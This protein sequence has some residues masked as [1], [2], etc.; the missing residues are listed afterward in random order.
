M[1]SNY[2]RDLKAD[3]QSGKVRVMVV[4]D[5]VGYGFDVPNI[6]RVITTKLE[7]YFEE[8]EQKWGR[9]GRDGQP[10]EAIAFAPPWVRNLPDTDPST[11]TEHDEEEKRG[12]LLEPTR[13]WL[14]PTPHFCSRHTAL[15]Y[16]SE[17]FPHH[18]ISSNCCGP[19]HDSDASALDLGRVQQWKEH[20]EQLAAD[21]EASTLRPRTDGAFRVLDKAMWTS[22]SHMLDRWSHRMWDQIRTSRELPCS[23][24]FP[25]FILDAVLDKAHLCTDLDNLKI[26]TRRWEY[27]DECGTV[28]LEFLTESM[29]GFEAIYDELANSGDS[30][31]GLQMSPEARALLRLAT[32]PILPRKRV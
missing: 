20:F 14:N 16:N 12:Q 4:T 6:H 9:A 2:R 1:P 22:L 30:D 29:A 17:P 18:T 26:I 5:T 13:A 11:K 21:A 23:V 24:F 7:T 10:A 15:H 25:P 28:L 8:F 3:F 27:F 31:G 32:L 19:I